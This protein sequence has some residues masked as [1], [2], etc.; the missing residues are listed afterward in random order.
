VVV[1]IPWLPQDEVGVQRW[2]VH[3]NGAD[4]WLEDRSLA[5]PQVP[6]DTSGPWSLRAPFNGKIVKLAVSVGE[7]VSTGQTLLVIESMKLE[8]SLLAKRAGI[9]KSVDVQQGQQ[10]GT[11]QALLN[12]SPEVS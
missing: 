9:I 7:H 5:A 2:H 6:Q 4:L 10:V 8:H 11:G 12:A 3:L 1:A